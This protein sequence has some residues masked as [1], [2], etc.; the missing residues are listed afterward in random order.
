MSKTYKIKKGKNIKL[1]GAA[2]KIIQEYSPGFF[3]VKPTD[4]NAVV[5]K[6]LVEEG[7]KV[8]AGQELFFDKKREYLRFSSPV[9]GTLKQI[10]RGEKRRIEELLIEADETQQHLDFKL[11]DVEKMPREDIV[12]AMLQ[13][14]VWPVIR[15]RPYDIIANPED[16]PKAIYIKAFDSAPLAPD[17]DILVKQEMDLLQKGIEVLKKI[18]AAPIHFNLHKKLNNTRMYDDLQGV[19]IRHFEGK[20]PVGNLSVQIFTI[21]PINKGDIIWHLDIQD[22]IYIARFFEESKVEH[23]KIFALCGSEIKKPMYYKTI[24][25]AKISNLIADGIKQDNVRIIS[26]NVLNGEKLQKDGFIGFYDNQITVI[27]E[28]NHYSFLG[29]ILP[30]FKKYSFSR[31]YFSWLQPNKKRR[32]HT[33][34]NG[35][36]RP[37]VM[38]GIYEKYLPMDILPMQ[39]CKAVLVNDIDEMENLGIYEVVPEDFALAE[40]ACPSK[41]D[42]QAIIAEGL[43]VIRKE[44]T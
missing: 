38:T 8:L 28:G 33:N 36:K 11:N 12:K 44:T 23:K 18:T 40:F 24:Q 37:F 31:T 26:G 7:D 9:S 1:Q 20:H 3:A 35:G 5:P 17:Y 39:L 19:D 21:S 10:K 16:N 43:E 27:P 14:G 42:M 6:L 41:I 4:F 2:D 32:L 13:A 30:G 22:V 34:L 25:G 15:Q 29:W